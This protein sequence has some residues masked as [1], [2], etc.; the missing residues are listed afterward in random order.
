MLLCREYFIF[1]VRTLQ[2]TYDSLGVL[3]EYIILFQNDLPSILEILQREVEEGNS[4]SNLCI[5]YLLN[6]VQ[7]RGCCSLPLQELG[8]RIFKE[9]KKKLEEQIQNSTPAF[10]LSA[11]DLLQRFLDVENI[12]KHP[13]ETGADRPNEPSR[14]AEEVDVDM[15]YLEDLCSKKDKKKI[16]KYFQKVLANNQRQL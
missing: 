4:Y 3:A 5:L 10:Q 12:W 2:P 7:N 9:G 8:L 15:E 11:K 6:E 16:V 14:P 13:P 1:A